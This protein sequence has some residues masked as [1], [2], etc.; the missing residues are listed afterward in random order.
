[1]KPIPLVTGAALETANAQLSQTRTA[2]PN[3]LDSNPPFSAPRDDTLSAG[4]GNRAKSNFL[5][6]LC[7]TVTKVGLHFAPTP[8]LRKL[9]ATADSRSSASAWGRA[10]PSS[11][12]CRASWCA[13][14][15]G[16]ESAKPREMRSMPLHRRPE[17]TDNSTVDGLGRTDTVGR[18]SV[19]F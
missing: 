19:F 7:E 13:R 8:E 9:E 11:T 15:C 17:S 18:R 16:W 1:M 5:P 2:L 6:I 4:C 10:A 3:C 12:E 14:G